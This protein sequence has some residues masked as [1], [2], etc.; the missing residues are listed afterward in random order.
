MANRISNIIG[1]ITGVTIEPG[2][3]SELPLSA[4]TKVV[5]SCFQRVSSGMIWWNNVLESESGDFSE[6]MK[7]RAVQEVNARL[8]AQHTLLDF[9]NR[10]SHYSSGKEI[11]VAHDLSHM[12]IDKAPED[13]FIEND[14][15]EFSAQVV[16]GN[17][18]AWAK[19]L[20]MADGKW[21][22]AWQ[23]PE[24]PLNPFLWEVS[25]TYDKYFSRY[26]ALTVLAEMGMYSPPPRKDDDLP[27]D[28]VLIA[29]CSK[30]GAEIAAAKSKSL[31]IRGIKALIRANYVNPLTVTKFEDGERIS[32]EYTA[33][34]IIQAIDDAQAL[35][36]EDAEVQAEKDRDEAATKE[37]KELKAEIKGFV[38]S[39]I[40]VTSVMKAMSNAAKEMAEGGVDQGIIADMMKNVTKKLGL[41]EPEKKDEPAPASQS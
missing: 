34:Q 32:V 36:I 21:P 8:T 29:A 1:V 33:A 2:K 28:I 5:F 11:D 15:Y 30:K 18:Y 37:T 19:Q 20:L 40:H 31:L 22:D 16:S 6:V 35:D 25:K 17:P 24:E 7:K 9:I 4:Q 27:S 26:A 38:R 12:S 3:F 39:A 13:S 41:A 23:A 14:E 10:A